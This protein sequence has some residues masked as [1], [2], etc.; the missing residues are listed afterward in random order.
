MRTSQLPTYRRVEEGCPNP[1]SSWVHLGGLRVQPSPE[2]K[3]NALGLLPQMSKH[4]YACYQI[5][6]ILHGLKPWKSLPSSVSASH[7]YLNRLLVS[8]NERQS[9]V[10][11][12]ISAV[13]HEIV[14]EPR[15]EAL[16]SF[17]SLNIDPA[18][19]WRKHQSA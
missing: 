14:V 5:H 19:L 10:R 2:I 12:R 18:A 6:C 1:Q 15:S 8:W 7:R 11:T 4:V 17:S 9:S 3:F 16:W 13:K